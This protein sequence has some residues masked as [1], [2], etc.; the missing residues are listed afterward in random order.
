MLIFPASMAAS[1][2]RISCLRCCYS[3]LSLYGTPS[4]HFVFTSKTLFF[5]LSLSFFFYRPSFPLAIIQSSILYFAWAH[6]STALAPLA[7]LLLCSS[8]RKL[9]MSD[10]L[11]CI[12][13]CSPFVSSFSPRPS[14]TKCP[15][16]CP[17]RFSACAMSNRRPVRW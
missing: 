1:D 2:F 12:L 17:F 8:F 15:T 7:L 9:L 10:R 11:F 13:S 5:S 4:I 6:P 14:P 16:V 3:R